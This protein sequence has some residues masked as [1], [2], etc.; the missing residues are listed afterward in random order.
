[1]RK[2]VT[3]TQEQAAD[4]VEAMIAMPPWNEQMWS[5][6]A[7]MIAAR[8]IRRGRH[9]TGKERADNLVKAVFPRPRKRRNE[10]KADA[11]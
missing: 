6:G 1:M 5:R 4:L 8:V 3:I 2:L 7:L 9:L 10:V 11:R